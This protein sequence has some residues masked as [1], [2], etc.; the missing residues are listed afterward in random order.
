MGHYLEKHNTTAINVTI[1]RMC[2]PGSVSVWAT[3]CCLSESKRRRS[4]F[5]GRCWWFSWVSLNGPVSLHP[6]SALSHLLTLSAHCHSNGVRASESPGKARYSRR[7][8]S[9]TSLC[10]NSHRGYARNVRCAL[11]WMY[12]YFTNPIKTQFTSAKIHYSA[13]CVCVCV[14][15]WECVSLSGE[16]QGEHG[17]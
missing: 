8:T 3:V 13:V 17:H 9:L 2:K 16:G 15:L 10:F 11:A 4:S 5:G 7:N 14:L 6:E 12:T 1:L